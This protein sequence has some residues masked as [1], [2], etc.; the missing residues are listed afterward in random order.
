[1]YLALI[2]IELLVTKSLVRAAA[3]SFLPLKL[4]SSM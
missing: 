1:M 3:S 2:Q 4:T